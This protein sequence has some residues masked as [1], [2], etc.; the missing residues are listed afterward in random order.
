MM[1]P[2][3]TRDSPKGNDRQ[4][5]VARLGAALL[6][7]CGFVASVCADSPRVVFEMIPPFFAGACIGMPRESVKIRAA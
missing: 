2:D 3:A 6:A 4:R 5:P 7:S 1:Q